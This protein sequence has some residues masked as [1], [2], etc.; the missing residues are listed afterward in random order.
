V[1]LGLARDEEHFAASAVAGRAMRIVKMGLGRVVMVRIVV[2]MVRG[3]HS[4]EGDMR[5]DG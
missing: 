2:M 4:Q 3:R 5:V 1:R